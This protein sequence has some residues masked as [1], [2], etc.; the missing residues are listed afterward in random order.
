MS[1]ESQDPFANIRREREKKRKE[2][3]SY[4]PFSIDK[5]LLE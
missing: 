1:Q 2:G 4:H 5:N 3:F